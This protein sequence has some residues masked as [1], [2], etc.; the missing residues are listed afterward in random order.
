MLSRMVVV[1]RRVC[2][3]ESVAEEMFRVMA[4]VFA[5]DDG[6]SDG[7]PLEPDDVAALL[8][9][10]D[11]WAVVAIEDGGIVGGLTAHALPMTRSRSKELF[12]YDLA[13]TTSRQRLGIGRA[14]VAELLSLGRKCGIDS[15]FVPA[16]NQDAHALE[17]YRAVGG[18]ASPVTIFTFAR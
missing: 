5:E 11:F 4:T 7:E 6:P 15:A 17:F 18:V 10:E 14:L 9:R 8:R 13:V 1:R 3:D 16:D 2:G 12:I